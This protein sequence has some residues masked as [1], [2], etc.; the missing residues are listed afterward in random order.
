M[1]VV[2]HRIPSARRLGSG[3][4]A[5]RREGVALAWARDRDGA[6]TPVRT[7]DAASR[8]A[9][10]P[11]T[12][13]GCGDELVARLGAVRA[14]HFAHRPG[15]TCPLTAPETALHFNAKERLLA[16]CAEAFAGRTAVTLL[17]RCGACRRLD[18]RPLRALGDAAAAEGAV[19]ALRA[20]VLV[21]RRG[22][23]A[24]ALEVLVTHAVDA[25]KEALLSAAGVPVV[26][27]DARDE[28]ERPGPGEAPAVEVLVHRAL[29]FPPCPA[30]QAQARAEAD[31]AVGGEAAQLAELEAYRARGLLEADAKGPRRG[32]RT[33]Q[34]AGAATAELSD[35]EVAN[36][37]SRFHCQDCGQRSLLV[38]IRLVRHPC[39]V[40]GERP[41][42]W[43]G[44]DGRLA[45]L[46][47]WK[48]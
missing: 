30:C 17:T 2:K 32:V 37:R 11:F 34:P 26:E 33:G 45:E 36:L 38:G 39:P 35:G 8:R 40:H 1:R 27:V 19:G 25:A 31:R 10:A 3:R 4:A 42:A 14:R 16:L 23:P 28:W 44:Y 24:V 41:V 15:S 18:A 46:R 9:R 20:D 47:W 12:C 22:A 43:R 48:R 13:P 5:L 21:T 6:I 29:G 7:L